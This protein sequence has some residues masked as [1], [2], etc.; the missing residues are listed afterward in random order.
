MTVMAS[1]R[2]IRN[3]EHL[4]D[5]ETTLKNTIGQSSGVQETANDALFIMRG[6]LSKMIE[7]HMSIIESNAAAFARHPYL[8]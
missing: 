2:L 5:Q 8:H 7:R 4:I 6:M 3:L 1:L